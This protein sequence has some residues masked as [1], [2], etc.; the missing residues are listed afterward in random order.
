MLGKALKDLCF[1]IIRFQNNYLSKEGVAM[2]TQELK[3]IKCSEIDFSNN[4]ATEDE[5]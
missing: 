4:P 5:R 2:L 1:P 3:G